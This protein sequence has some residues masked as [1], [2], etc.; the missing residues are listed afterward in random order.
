M[1]KNA[2]KST[3]QLRFAVVVQRLVVVFIGLEEVDFE[4]F[5][6]VARGCG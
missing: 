5:V 4:S 6:G 2:R 1:R 3:V